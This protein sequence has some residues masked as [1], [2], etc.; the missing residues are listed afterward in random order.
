[1]RS[2]SAAWY[3]PHL[4]RLHEDAAVREGDLRQLAWLA[5]GFADCDAFLAELTL[6][7]P[8]A[9]RDEADAPGLWLRP[10]RRAVDSARA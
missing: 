3:R 8:Q 6:D 4:H 10:W 1:M 7:P 5:A 2:S 9:T